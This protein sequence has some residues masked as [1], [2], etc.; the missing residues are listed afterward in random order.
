MIRAIETGKR[1]TFVPW[2]IGVLAWGFDAFPLLAK[3]IFS[4]L[5]RARIKTYYEARRRQGDG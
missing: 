2:T 5:N 4:R 1:V 3:P